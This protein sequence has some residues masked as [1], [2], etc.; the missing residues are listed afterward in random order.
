MAN[1]CNFLASDSHAP[2]KPPYF[3]K[4]S[5]GYWKQHMQVYIEANDILMWEV[6][7]NGPVILTRAH[8]Q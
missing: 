6:I 3:D 1:L 4:T 8:A 7:V 2:S 5:Y